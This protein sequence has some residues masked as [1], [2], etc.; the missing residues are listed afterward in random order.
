M[1]SC[2]RVYMFMHVHMHMC[3]YN[4][5]WLS[6]WNTYVYMSIIHTH[7]YHTHIHIHLYIY[8]YKYMRLSRRTTYIFLVFCKQRRRKVLS[9]VV[10]FSFSGVVRKTPI[11]WTTPLKTSLFI[12]KILKRASGKKITKNDG[13]SYIRVCTLSPILRTTPLKSIPGTTGSAMSNSFWSAPP[14]I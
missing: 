11:L 3:T 9:G 4:Y 5:I 1:C 13:D 14:R 2:V 6:R 12:D 8:I 10:L 7:E